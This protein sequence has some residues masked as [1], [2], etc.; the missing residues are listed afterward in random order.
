MKYIL[1][2]NKRDS[3]M[4][5]FLDKGY[6]DLEEYVHP[7]YPQHHLFVKGQHIY[8]DFDNRNAKLWVDFSIAD[9]LENWFDLKY[10]DNINIIKKWVKH[11]YE[12]QYVSGIGL[13]YLT[14]LYL[15]ILP[16]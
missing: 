14:D 4:I 3:V 7:D 11:R 9:D 5:H 10:P 8:L 12:L 15:D 6:G 16:L 2:E 13:V 1:S